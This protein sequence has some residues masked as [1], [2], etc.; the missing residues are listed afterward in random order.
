MMIYQVI[1]YLAQGDLPSPAKLAE[2][3]TQGFTHLLNVSGIDLY[4]LYSREQL[5]AFTLAQFTFKDVFSTGQV[6]KTA[7]ATT[8]DCRLYCEQTSVTERFQFCKAVEQLLAWLK[9]RSRCYVFCQRG[10]G[11]SPCVV[12]AALTYYYQ[13]KPE[14]LVKT[15]KFLNSYAILSLTSYA[16]T[17]WFIQY[18]LAI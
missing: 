3:K 2:L 10:I 5:S 12:C 6:V 7:Q 1:Q 8:V 15:L 13:P 18:K 9:N 14:E 16:A 11:R 4:K 17:Q